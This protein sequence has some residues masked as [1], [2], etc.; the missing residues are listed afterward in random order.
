MRH[1]ALI[2]VL[3]FS[4]PALASANTY[5]A[6][7]LTGG[8]ASSSGEEIGYEA[9][10]AFDAN[11]AT[12]WGGDNPQTSWWLLYDLGTATATAAKW[13]ATIYV[14]GETSYFLKTVGVYGSDDNITYN[15]LTT[16]T[17]ENTG[18]DAS[19]QEFEFD[20]TTAYRYYKFYFPDTYYENF[21]SVKEI[22][23]YECTDCGATSTAS[24]TLISVKDALL[25]YLFLVLD[26]LWFFFLCFLFIY[27]L[28][29][30]FPVF[31]KKA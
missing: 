10:K 18:A 4:V 23:G 19:T 30:V 26:A 5:G 25:W 1:A 9:D 13:S 29:F 14:Q 15:F 17:V 16:S 28:N 20:N 2:L 22:G 8:T 31:P 24:T 12:R 3:V 7:F 11:T 6:N 21:N 27:C